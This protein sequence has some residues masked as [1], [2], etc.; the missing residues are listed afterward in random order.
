MKNAQAIVVLPDSEYGQL[1]DSDH[2]HWLS[3]GDVS[4]QGAAVELLVGVLTLLGVPVPDEGMAALRFWGQAG[5]R[6]GSWMAAA[7]PIHLEAR[8]RDLR[9]RSL[10]P[11]QVAPAELRD[12]FDTL[13]GELGED[14]RH[15]FAKMGMSGYLHSERPI[16]T[17]SVSAVV[18]DGHVPDRFPPSGGSE[19]VFHQ[20]QGELQMLLHDHEVNIERQKAGQPVINSLW[21]WGGGI[22]PQAVARPVPDLYS[23]D[24]LFNGFWASCQ[25]PFESFKDFADCRS[26]S[27]GGFVAVVPGNPFHDGLN[28]LKQVIGVGGLQRLTL[29]FRDG[30]TVS[31]SRFDRLRFWRRAV[32]LPGDDSLG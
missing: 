24:P 2:C 9:I 23:A 18:A 15:S 22:A 6:S 3:R 1:S 25:R 30:V 14:Q 21:F 29:L 12:L 20:L 32:A 4:P 10:A 17:A 31:L 8:L 19:Q 11:G 26:R 5:H 27:P 7:D 28:G 13:Q 16:A